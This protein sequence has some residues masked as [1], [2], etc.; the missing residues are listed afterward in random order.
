MKYFPN[1]PV[2]LTI[3]TDPERIKAILRKAGFSFR[4]GK[5]SHTVW[6]HPRLPGAIT[7]AGNDGDDAK[8]YQEQEIRNI[9][10]RLKEVQE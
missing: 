6:E 5:G 1:P 3:F 10:K 2:F 4:P 8:S 7:L 9:L